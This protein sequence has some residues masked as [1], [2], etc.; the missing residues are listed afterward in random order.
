MCCSTSGSS[1]YTPVLIVSEKTWP[2]D[3]FSRKRST[4]PSSSV[5]TI[6]NSSGFSTD[7]RPIVTAAP[8][9]LVEVDEGAEVEVAQRVAGDDEEGLVQLVPRQPHRAGRSERGLLDRVLHVHA[10]ALAVAEVAADRLREER[11]RDDHVLEAVAAEQLDD[12]LHA[13]LADDRHHRL[14]LVRGERAEARALAAGHDD[15]LHR[16][17]TFQAERRYSAPAA[18]AR[19]TPVQ[20]IQS[21]QLVP[22]SVTITKASDAYS[23]H[24]AAFPRKLTSSS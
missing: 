6:P 2:Q 8:L 9:L 3:G 15:G 17:I 14:R 18:S 22:S 16:R 20:K 7:L 13:R 1:T 23:S 21:G 24:V 19:A 10:E 11:D 5:T 12:V 4:R